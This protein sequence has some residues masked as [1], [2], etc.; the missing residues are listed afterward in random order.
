MIKKKRLIPFVIAVVSIVVLF[1]AFSGP[2]RQVVSDVM[3]EVKKGPFVE[4]ITTT[5]EL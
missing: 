5:G 2:S 4:D 3:V 1:I